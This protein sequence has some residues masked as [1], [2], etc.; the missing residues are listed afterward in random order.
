MTVDN[1]LDFSQLIM[2][3][4]SAALLYLGETSSEQRQST[5]INIPLARQ[6]IDII[7]L[8]KEK[9]SGNLSDQETRLIEQVLFDLQIRYQK[10]T[11]ESSA[12]D[13]KT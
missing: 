12:T 2:G 5:E 9:T 6:N 11:A 1:E 10:A 3:F 8:L 13:K 4:C 7:A